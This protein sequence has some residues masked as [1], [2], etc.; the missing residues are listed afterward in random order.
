VTQC[1]SL[2]V[3]KKSPGWQSGRESTGG[4]PTMIDTYLLHTRDHQAELRGD[5]IQQ[6]LVAQARQS[7]ATQKRTSRNVPRIV[8]FLHSVRALHP[9]RLGDVRSA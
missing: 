9:W 6:R 7:R 5:V 1:G 8:G 4:S 2:R 3:G